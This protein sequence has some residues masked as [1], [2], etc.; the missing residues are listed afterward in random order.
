MVFLLIAFLLIVDALN[1]KSLATFRLMYYMLDAIYRSA[2]VET[3]VD[4]ILFFIMFLGGI[5]S[6]PFLKGSYIAQKILEIFTWIL[7]LTSVIY[8]L[9]L[10]LSFIDFEN[11]P[12]DSDNAPL[13]TKLPGFLFILL[14][15]AVL[16]GLRCKIVNEYSGL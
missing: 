16:S 1:T 14:E 5:Y 15:V 2:P 10:Q 9:F 4:S 11:I 12:P 7:V 6:W 13:G 3:V 8:F